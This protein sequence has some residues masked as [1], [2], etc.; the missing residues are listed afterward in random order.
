MSTREDAKKRAIFLKRLREQHKETVTRSQALLKDQ[1]AIRRQICQPTREEP[2]TIPEIAKI[3][4]IPAHEVLWHLTA[5][6]KY[7]LVVET[8]MC[9]EYYLYQR[10]EGKK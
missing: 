2:K 8:G 5:M 1:K 4:D 10:V 6:K 7:G 9:G 3:T